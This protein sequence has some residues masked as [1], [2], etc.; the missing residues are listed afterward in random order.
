VPINYYAQIDF[1]AFET[2]IDK[3]DGVEIDVPHEIKIDPIGQYNTITL[4]PGKVR[5]YGPEALAYA[6]AR[7]TEGGDFDRAQRQQQVIL[8]IR[9]RALKPEVMYRLLSN[10]NEIYAELPLGFTPHDAGYYPVC[11]V[12]AADPTEN[13]RQGAMFA[14]SGA[15]CQIT[16][17]DRYPKPIPD[18]I[19]EERDMYLTDAASLLRCRMQTWRP[20]G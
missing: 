16:R 18:K 19:R 9:K 13:I 7:Y 10:A 8:A 17:R 5:L 15:V 4:Q 20:H 2:L 14:Q 1:G 12:G 3:I 6:R 11:L